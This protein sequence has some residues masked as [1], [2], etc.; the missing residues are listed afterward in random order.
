MFYNKG[1][2]VWSWVRIPG[3][4]HPCQK[5]ELILQQSE[6]A[7]VYCIVKSAGIHHALDNA[8]TAQ[9]S[10]SLCKKVRKPSS[11]KL[12]DNMY[13]LLWLLLLLTLLSTN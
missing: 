6:E 4:W 8:A 1:H 12:L 13:L 3:S 11:T 9:A 7:Y 2:L 10:F 5:F